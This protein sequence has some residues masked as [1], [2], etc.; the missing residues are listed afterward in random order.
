LGESDKLG[1]LGGLMKIAVVG[2]G[3][4]GLV[5]GACLAESGN[6][7]R[8]VDLDTAKIGMLRGGG[9]PIFEPGLDGMIA[10]NAGA[11]RLS[12]T[13]TLS[14]ALEGAE[15]IFIAVGTPTGEDGSADL[16]YVL[17]AARDIGA[18]LS[19]PAIVVGKST[20]P[21]GT[22]TKI[23]DAIAAALAQR[24]AKH[25]FKVVSN[26]EFLRE[27]VA[28]ADFMR[29]DRIVIG[30][31]DAAAVAKM[32]E[33][34]RPFLAR[35]DQL[36][37][38]DPASAELIKYA[39]NAMLATR[40][41]FMNEIANFAEKVGADVD[42]VRQG[43]ASD[44]RIGP[45]FL[46]A[47]CGFGGSCFPKD[48][49]AL[50]RMAQREGQ[51]LLV[52]R[53]VENTNEAQ[54]EI[55]FRKLRDFFESQGGLKGKVIALWGLAFKPDTDD[56]REAPSLTL[57]EDLL[58]AGAEVRA[59][60]PVARETA[61]R[62]LGEVEGVAFCD[63]AMAAVRGAHA[64]AIVTEWAEFR[65]ADIKHLGRALKARFVVDGRNIFSPD[66]VAE[67]GMTYASIGRQ[68][69]AATSALQ[70]LLKVADL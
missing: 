47:G 14:E 35:P 21:V 6:H 53:A 15:V 16:Q 67:A 49:R 27:G 52:V 36:L 63:S 43:L 24:G 61:R 13:T 57:I 48:V 20:A 56:V 19:G 55:M 25:A 60:D 31:S 33:L 46:N 32:R 38:C 7:V 66:D 11:G 40:I 22:T 30:S 58:E 45:Q 29:P 41:S 44:P 23:R 39:A 70:P 50:V 42:S 68:T 37:V 65:Q 5:T 51:E 3:Y 69:R 12:F 28:I 54:K 59:Y 8:V 9:C 2:A 1:K 34:Y 4:V 17:A 62:A 26:P 18:C 10:G 64:L